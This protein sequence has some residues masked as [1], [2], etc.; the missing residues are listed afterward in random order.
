MGQRLVF[1]VFL[2]VLLLAIGLLAYDFI[3]YKRYT[4]LPPAPADSETINQADYPY[5]VF[6]ATYATLDENNEWRLGYFQPVLAG[7]ETDRGANY[8]L[9]RYTDD[10]GT[11]HQAK[12]FVTGFIDEDNQIESIFYSGSDGNKDGQLAFDDLKNNLLM[13]KQIGIE[14]LAKAPS[15]DGRQDDFCLKMS[16]FCMLAKLVEESSN[17]LDEFVSS[18]TISNQLVIPATMIYMKLYER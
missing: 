2:I 12:V 6:P 4:S 11:T 3:L 13:D 9:V 7:F 18:S 14:Y 10:L 8:L 5:P 15:Q 16:K 1:L 17:E